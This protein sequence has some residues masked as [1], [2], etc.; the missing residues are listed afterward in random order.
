MNEVIAKCFFAPKIWLPTWALASEGC[1]GLTFVGGPT[2]VPDLAV[3]V[4][5]LDMHSVHYFPPRIHLFFGENSWRVRETA[6]HKHIPL[7]L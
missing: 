5:A 1:E 7:P 3:N 4:A 6:S 2:N